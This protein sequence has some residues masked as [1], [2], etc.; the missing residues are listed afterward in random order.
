MEE[1][2]RLYISSW[3]NLLYLPTNSRY[4]TI[5]GLGVLAFTSLKLPLYRIKG[6]RILHI[7][8][9]SG[10]SFFRKSMI[11]V[12]GRILGYK[13]ILHI[14]AGDF[15]DFVNKAGRRVVLAGLKTAHRIIVLSNTWQH[16]FNESLKCKNVSVVPNMSRES[17]SSPT[18]K[19]RDKVRFIF[20]GVL[21]KAKGVD[22]LVKAY[23][24]VSEQFNNE[25]E[26]IIAGSG[27]LESQLKEFVDNE[28]KNNKVIFTGWVNHEERD[29]LL[30][31]SY[32]VVLPSLFEC[33]P[34]SLIEGMAAGCGIVATRTS[35]IT[36]IVKNGENG[37]LVECGDVD[38]LAEAMSRYIKNRELV[39]IHGS[40]SKKIVEPHSPEK[41]KAALGKVYNSI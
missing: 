3:D 8:S 26:L 39:S 29:R 12:W 16:Y 21:T 5:A 10:K 22:T 15:P 32:V 25:S 28:I 37:F 24:R 7:H 20:L 30:G 4:G 9:A 38:G 35:G 2:G 13:I 23:K 11:A 17:Q 27:P 18:T 36:D 19:C 31:L 40:N 41:V 14:H 34:M 1:L 33:Q 6:K